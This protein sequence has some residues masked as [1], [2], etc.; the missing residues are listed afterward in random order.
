MCRGVPFS[1]MIVQNK[2]FCA[3]HTQSKKKKATV[4]WHVNYNNKKEKYLQMY[5]TWKHFLSQYKRYTSLSKQC[6]FFL[7]CIYTET[8]KK[9]CLFLYNKVEKQRER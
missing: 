2:S 9:V 1:Q 8:K 3:S 4:K 5:H 6:Y 7:Q